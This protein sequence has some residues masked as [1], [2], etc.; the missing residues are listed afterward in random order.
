MTQTGG[1]TGTPVSG[2]S[3]LSVAQAAPMYAY[4]TLQAVKNYITQMPPTSEDDILTEFIG[5]AARLIESYKG[6][7]YDVRRETRVFDT[8]QAAVSHF[9]VYDAHYTSYQAEP[10]LRLDEDLL[11]V[12]ELLNGDGD[13]LTGAMYVVEPANMTPKSRIRLRRGNNWA[14]A[15][16][17]P[18]QAISLCGWWGYHDRYAEAWALSGASNS[19]VA[20]DDVSLALVDDQVGPF[21]IGQLVRIEDEL[22]L[23]NGLGSL[24]APA[25]E[26]ERGYNGS[27]AAAHAAG[28][29]I[30]IFR[31][32]GTIVQM[33]MRL[34]K[35]RYEQR[36]ND[37]FDRSY[38]AGTGIITTPTSLPADVERILGARKVRI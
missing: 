13:E 10:P 19:Q 25:L 3:S 5:W 17:G 9:G 37:A 14:E 4:V 35:W 30:S 11:E 34:V 15:D 33:A 31:P 23:V 6:R 38:V 26:L 2:G 28:V 21:E 24:Q 20:I 7:R 8:P 29:G 12:V 18:E 27:L 22:G 16:E 1:G 32:M 36:S